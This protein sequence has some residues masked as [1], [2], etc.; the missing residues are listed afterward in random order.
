[1]A[2][3]GRVSGSLRS[4]LPEARTVTARKASVHSVDWP[5]IHEV[6]LPLRL[7]NL[8]QHLKWFQLQNAAFLEMDVILQK[9]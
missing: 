8:F 4:E 5:S 3:H 9:R 2:S 7:L 6:K 1:M